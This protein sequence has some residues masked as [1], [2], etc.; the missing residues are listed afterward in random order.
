MFEDPAFID[1]RQNQ[2]SLMTQHNQFNPR[3]EP[4]PKCDPMEQ[5]I[6]R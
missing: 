4:H 3:Q 6:M 5:T 1:C 2:A